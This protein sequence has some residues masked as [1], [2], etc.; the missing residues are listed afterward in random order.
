VN[1]SLVRAFP[2]R[3]APIVTGVAKALPGTRL[4]PSGSVTASRSRI[5][6]GLVVD[7]EPVLIPHRIYNPEPS[8]RLADGLSRMEELVVAGI[9]SRHHDG[10]VRQRWLGT[11]LDA[12]EPWAA[13][14]VIQLL[15]EYVIEICRDIE[16][17]TRTEPS[18]R[19]ALHQHLTA[20]MDDNRCFAEL[21]RKRAIS[22][23]SCCHRY[24]YPSPDTYPALAALSA[25]S[26]D[27]IT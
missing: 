10:H 18:V 9:Y 15:G 25:L 22:Y 1:E 20:F 2:A 14:F 3:L 24:R 6:P 19:P 26:S 17:F 16:R 21:T 13:P 23:W 27:R 12:D 7:G 11:L 8:P 4:S 5:W